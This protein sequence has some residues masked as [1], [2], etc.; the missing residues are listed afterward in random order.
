MTS[1]AGITVLARLD[2]QRLPRKAMRDFMGK[3][4]VVRVLERVQQ[5]GPT[6]L[7]TSDRPVDDELAD[8]GERAGV[9]VFRGSADDVLGRLLKAA[10]VCNFDPVVRI[11]GDSPF[12]DPA[13]IRTMIEIHRK[14][15]V[16]VTTNVMPRT[17]PPGNSVEVL[18]CAALQRVDALAAS[19]DDREHVT[20]YIYR[21]AG[22]FRIAN[23]AAPD[24]RYQGIALT[25]DSPSD[26]D[27]LRWI[28]ANFPD[29][30]SAR[31][32]D[33]VAMAKAYRLQ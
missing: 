31:F 12:I 24:A 17:F 22:A 10:Q 21:N 1:V 4:L 13:L 29:P 23:H 11:S 5:A 33:I 7:A 26:L 19:V 9:R 32:D 2:S 6:V 15:D 30:A 16:D 14:A 20:S 8:I 18:S 25:V 28:A 27:R 3:P